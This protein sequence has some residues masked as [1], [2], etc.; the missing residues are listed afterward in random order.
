M[1]AKNSGFDDIRRIRRELAELRGQRNAVITE[2]LT[3]VTD[4][5]AVELINRLAWG[6][7]D[8]LKTTQKL[9]IDCFD[10]DFSAQRFL[11]DLDWYPQNGQLIMLPFLP[12]TRPVTNH[13]ALNA[14][15]SCYRKLR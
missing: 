4:E 11:K 10:F 1:S 3:S 9:L 7:C 2:H 15:L 8:R 14:S 5:I 13:P 6:L 12:Q